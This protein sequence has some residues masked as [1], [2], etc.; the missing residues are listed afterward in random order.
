MAT[1]LATEPRPAESPRSVFHRALRKRRDAVVAR[2]ETRD[3]TPRLAG[4]VFDLLIHVAL[5]PDTDVDAT[6][7]ASFARRHRLGSDRPALPTAERVMPLL[8]ALAEPA[9]PGVIDAVNYLFS[10]GFAEKLSPLSP[11]DRHAFTLRVVGLLPGVER[12][13]P[14]AITYFLDDVCPEEDALRFW[15][16]YVERVAAEVSRRTQVTDDAASPWLLGQLLAL[17]ATGLSAGRGRAWV[18]LKRHVTRILLAE[19]YRWR[20]IRALAEGCNDPHMLHYVCSSPAMVEDAE[21]LHVFLTRGDSRL[22]SCALFALQMHGDQEA[23]VGR[24]LEYLRSRPLPEIGERLV[25]IYAQAHLPERPSANLR[26]LVGGLRALARERAREGTAE[27]LV[28]AIRADARALRQ[29]LLLADLAHDAALVATLPGRRLL[30]RVV[31]TFYQTFTPSGVEHPLN[32]GVFARGVRRALGALIGADAP[33]V[34]DRLETFG[35]ELAEHAARWAGDKASAAARQQLLARFCEVYAAQ[36]SAVCRTL[37]A[38][39]DTRDAGRLLY[40]SL[41]RVYLEHRD[42]TDGLAAFGAIEQMLP[43]LAPELL[44][45]PLDQ[46]EMGAII[47]AAHTIAEIERE[48]GAGE[49]DLHDDAHGRIEEAP[50]G[51]SPLLVN[52]PDRERPLVA[53]VRVLRRRPGVARSVLGAYLGLDLLRDLKDRAL[54]ALGLRWQGEI[55]LTDREVIITTVRSLG[56]RVIDRTGDSHALEDL[57]AVQVRQRMRLFYVVLGLLGMVTAGVLGGHLFFVGLRA[58]DLMTGLIGGAFLLFGV[59]FDAAMTRIAQANRRQVVLEIATASRPRNTV[60]LIDIERGAEVLD[61]FMAND[62]ERRELALL[63]RWSE[64]DVDWEPLEEVAS[65]ID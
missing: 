55:R 15:Q 50:I 44:R 3:E 56:G 6:L 20:F 60:L 61:A 2:F 1:A 7:L 63:E 12:F 25:E 43:T 32:D 35:L 64:T 21:V 48:T 65:Q 31:H 17:D 11:G 29:T 49:A 51:L 52:R 59:L 16:A 54:A 8:D 18:V 34:R 40:Q 19:R 30:E 58:G 5:N 10:R 47:D 36:V 4:L 9:E 42:V 38:R 28:Q 13:G 26:Q 37:Y 23:I 53:P 22:V 33:R 57:R 39:V 45:Q 27:S 41:I 62:A 14:F 24:V 46:L